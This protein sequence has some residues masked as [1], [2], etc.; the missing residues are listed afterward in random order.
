MTTSIGK[1]ERKS[2]QISLRILGALRPLLEQAATPENMSVSR[3]IVEHGQETARL[4]AEAHDV[5]RL[6]PHQP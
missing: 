1:Q 3:F 5:N 6:H 4:I 2:A